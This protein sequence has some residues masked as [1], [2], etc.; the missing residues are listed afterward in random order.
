MAAQFTRT[1]GPLWRELRWWM[2]WAMSSLPVPVGPWS[3]TVARV[4]A[5]A[6]TSS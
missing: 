1:N 3:S 5:T 2:A 4:S 6:A